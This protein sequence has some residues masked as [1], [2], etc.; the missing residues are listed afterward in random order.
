M[1]RFLL[2]V[3]LLCTLLSAGLGFF[4]R[5]KFSVLSDAFGRTQ[6]QIQAN[7]NQL[8]DVQ[9]KLGQT[10]ERL[11]TQERLTQQERDGRNAELNDTKTKLNQVS[12]QL[13]RLQNENKGL[14]AALTEAGRNLD[15]KQRAEEDRQAL[16]S[17]LLQVEA[18]LNEMRMN[19][20]ARTRAP[21][22]LDGSILSINREA[23]AVTVSLGK[24]V[25]LTPGTRLTVKKEGE[26][27]T[28]LRAVSVENDTSVAEFVS[29]TPDIFTRVAVG[30]TVTVK[31]Q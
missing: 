26:T 30:D 27:L 8:K 22:D 31:I 17:R 10:Q 23:K 2:S 12:D 16:A 21:I 4:N 19:S 14:T 24:N 5:T 11:A 15:Q 9:D 29:P 6:Q 7:Q 18:D 20:R 13:A 1:V 28:Q 25:G 3:A